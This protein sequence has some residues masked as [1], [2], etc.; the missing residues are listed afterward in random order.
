MQILGVSRGAGLSGTKL[1][2]SILSET[3]SAF[4]GTGLKT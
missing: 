4:R 3:S 1:A 2:H